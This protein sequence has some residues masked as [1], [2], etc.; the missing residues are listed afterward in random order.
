MDATVYAP[1][2]QVPSLLDWLRSEHIEGLSVQR[3]TGRPAPTEMG[4]DAAAVDLILSA[5]AVTALAGS[6]AIWLRTRKSQVKI[7]VKSG[8]REVEVE[9]SNVAN[10]ETVIKKALESS[11]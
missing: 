5:P 4:F 9:S 6:L 11:E 8:E 2:D 1:A 7:R 3:A 10:A